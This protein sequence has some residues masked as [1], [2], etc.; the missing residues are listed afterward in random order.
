MQPL[1]VS[2]IPS[3]VD[4]RQLEGAQRVHIS[5]KYTIML[6]CTRLHVYIS[7]SLI[8][9]LHSRR[10]LM[11]MTS[12]ITTDVV[13]LA[14][15]CAEKFIWNG[16][17]IFVHFFTTPIP[18]LNLNMSSESHENEVSN[19]ILSEQKYS[20]L[21][22]HE[23]NIFLLK[24]YRAN[25]FTDAVQRWCRSLFIDCAQKDRRTESITV[26][27][28]HSPRSLGGYNNLTGVGKEMLSLPLLSQY[29]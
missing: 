8:M 24:Q 14:Y 10:L 9:Y 5:A 17:D 7:T 29:V 12:S 25:R 28:R 18:I 19:D 21:F 11:I 6:W 4:S 13:W 20:Q 3:A 27:P 22:T 15:F 23:S 16:V 1:V 26:Y 2:N